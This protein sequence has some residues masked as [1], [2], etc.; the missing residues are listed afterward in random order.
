MNRQ[1]CSQFLHRETHAGLDGPQWL[2]RS[3]RNLRLT[4]STE[5]SE[6]ED[7]ALFFR[8]LSKG[9]PDM[10]SKLGSFSLAPRIG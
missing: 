5:I 9:S 6:L 10:L 7:L 1:R 8:E 4:E 2:S 3:L